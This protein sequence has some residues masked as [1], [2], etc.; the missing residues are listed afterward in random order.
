[1]TSLERICAAL[2]D[3]SVQYG[4]VGGH[5]VALHG[6]VRGTV[7]VDLVLRWTEETLVRAEAA[8]NDIGLVSQ[9]PIHAKDVFANRDDYV[10]NRNLAGL[11]P[12]KKHGRL[13]AR[14]LQPDCKPK[15]RS[16]RLVESFA[17]NIT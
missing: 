8:L 3:A 13:T 6:A 12:S 17:Y 10:Q 11:R 4:I 7:D 16:R 14:E 5:A 2:R 9:L 1:M 15:P